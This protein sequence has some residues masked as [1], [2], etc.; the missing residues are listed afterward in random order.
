METFTEKA[1]S[2][3][4]I[5]SEGNGYISRES[6]VIKAGAGK[7]EAGTV[8]GKIAFGAATAAAKA[9]GNTGNGT[10]SA[11]TVLDG[12][13]VGVYK[14][15]FTSATAW[16]LTDP[17]GFA[18]PDGANGTANAN[19]IGFT[20]TAGGTAF[21]AGDGFDITVAAGSGKYVPSPATASDGSQVAAAILGYGVDA[22]SEDVEVVAVTNDAEVK[23]PM[24]I[25][26]ATVNDDTKRNTK[27]TQLRAVGIKAR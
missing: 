20:T 26:D 6:I 9:G 14:L 23:N 17:E 22:T 16:T 18:L 12:A 5:L 3:A 25:F 24:L 11:V 4:F 15:R 27:L 19:D 21:V 8:L 13:K 7:L 10:I 1:R 2:L